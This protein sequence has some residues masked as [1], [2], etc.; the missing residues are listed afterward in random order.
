MQI[1]TLS[2]EMK[3]ERDKIKRNEDFF[4]VTFK[5]IFSSDLHFF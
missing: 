2:L 5:S 1:T 4:S 3:I